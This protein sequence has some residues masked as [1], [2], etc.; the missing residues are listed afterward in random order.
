MTL[1]LV[2]IH[3][4]PNS[5]L[6]F[7]E[8]VAHYLKLASRWIPSQSRGFALEAAF[9][10]FLEGSKQRPALVLC[11]QRGKTPTSE[12]FAAWIGQRRDSGSGQ[13]VLAIGPADGWSPQ[14]LQKADLRLSFGAMTLP[15]ALARLVL[16]EQMYRAATILGGHPYHS[17]H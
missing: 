6:P 4:R 13:L 14:M 9:V 17:G 15:H 12:E 2:H 5:P 11:D 16:A 3:P 7:E 8:E 10:A 1:T